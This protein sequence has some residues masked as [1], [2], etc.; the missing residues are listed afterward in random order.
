MERAVLAV[1]EA[2]GDDPGR[3][4]LRQTPA[5]VA[6]MYQ[7]VFSG[8][9][10]DP[11]RQF[12]LFRVPHQDGIVVVKDIAFH[13]MCEHHLLPFFGKVH[14]AYLPRDSRVTGL[15]S[16]T[17]VTDVLSRRPQLQERLTNDIADALM[18]CLRPR[19]LLVVTEAQHLCMSM[20]EGDKYGTTA[21]SSAA[22]GAMLSLPRRRE[23]LLMMNLPHTVAKGSNRPGRPRASHRKSGH[24][25]N[26][27]RA[28]PRK[29]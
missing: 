27:R 23:A 29:A 10:E 9:G 24:G 25:R 12:S 2:I 5:R 3:E 14:V 22:R 1:L 18:E 6:R 20:G 13:S 28:A 17:R 8:V 16:L 7:K 26:A 19:G 4:G 11:R 15:N 21:V